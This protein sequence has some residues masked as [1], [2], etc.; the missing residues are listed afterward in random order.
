MA[1][2]PEVDASLLLRLEH[3]VD[4]LLARHREPER[5]LPGILAAH[6]YDARLAPRVGVDVARH[7]ARTG[8]GLERRRRRRLGP[9]PRFLAD[10]GTRTF[11]PGE[12]LP[13]RVWVARHAIWFDEVNDP[14][15]FP[16]DRRSADRSDLGPG[17]PVRRRPRR[18]P[19]GVVELFRDSPHDPDPTL[20]ATL[21]SLG[22]RLGAHFARAR[23]AAQARYGE[24]L[25]RATVE[26]ALDAVVMADSDGLIVEF[27]PAASDIFG[28]TREQA[29]GRDLADLI[30]PPSL[31]GEH[32][33]AWAATSR[34]GSGPSSDPGSRPSASAATAPSSRSS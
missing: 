4:D 27:N 18:P 14:I 32:R 20:L 28:W 25:L 29:V 11:A 7:G 13:G 2:S 30:V 10:S 8:R 34:R 24:A 9:V 23:E 33:R 17:V 26:S 16:L 31:R 15:A 6:R 22:H 1:G 3:A 5:A 19:Q 12:G 21:A